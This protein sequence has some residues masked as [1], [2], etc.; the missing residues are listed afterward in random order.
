MSPQMSPQV[1]ASLRLAKVHTR[2]D[3]HAKLAALWLRTP[4][5]E[6]LTTIYLAAKM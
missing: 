5:Y 1:P 4:V 2:R 3:C 6:Y